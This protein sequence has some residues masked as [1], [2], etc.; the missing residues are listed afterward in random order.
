MADKTQAEIYTERAQKAIIA[1]NRSTLPT[2]P[3]PWL[4]DAFRRQNDPTFMA[5]LRR[6]AGWPQKGDEKILDRE[7]EQ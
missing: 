5:R 1:I 4:R 2:N 6:Q 3:P 7:E